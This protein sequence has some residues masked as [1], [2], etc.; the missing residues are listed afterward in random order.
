MAAVL[1]QRPELRLVKVADSAKDN[2]TY[3][4]DEL[5][6]G[7]EVIDFHDAAEHLKHAFEVAH[8]ESSP[9]ARTLFETY[10]YVLRDEHDC[11][12]KVIRALVQLRDR[13]PR[14][15]ALATELGCFRRH[16][17]RMRYTEMKAQGLPIGSGVVEAAC[18][19]LVT[20]RNR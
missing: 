6:A 7:A 20:Q 15:P 19:T 9:M 18:K 5:A 10:R 12:E 3:L 16:R 14:R 2:W 1:Q 17:R 4:S 11:V 8:G 13:Y